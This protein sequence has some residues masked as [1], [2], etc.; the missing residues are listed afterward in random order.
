[1]TPRPLPPGPLVAF[2]GDDLTGSSAAMEVLAFAGLDTVLFLAPPTPERLAAFAGHRAVGIAGMARSQGP[3]WMDAHLP[4]VFRLLAGLGAP[5][6]HYKVC[7]T[8]DSAPHVGSIGRAAEL[9]AEVFRVGAESW[10]PMLVADPG[11]GRY[12]S[13]GHLFAMAGPDGHRLDRHP[14]MARHPVTPMDEA[15]LGRHLARQTALPVG[16]VDFVAMKRGE[17]SARLARARAAGAR[18]VSLD[19]L[20]HETL[21]EAGRLIWEEGGSPTFTVGS[22]G[23]GA[24]LVAWWREAGLLPAAPAIPVPPPVDRIAAVS[25]SVSPVTAGQ[26]A[27]AVQNGF[28]GLRIDPSLAVD[29]AAWEREVGR[30]GEAALAALGRGRDPLVYS[31]AGPDDPAV[32]ALRD[33]TRTAGLSEEVV[34]DRIGAGLGTILNRVVRQGRLTRAVI[35]GGDTSGRVAA[36]LGIDALAALAPMA[37]GAPLC[38]AYTDDGGA[39]LEIALKGGQV[40]GPDFFV[41][42]RRG[43]PTS[44]AG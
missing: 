24:A 17:G 32:A 9:G 11:M 7:S 25:G 41:A 1:M 21:V 30:A 10:I 20:D 5:V 34:N 23:V 18:I 8:F 33:A 6:A 36:R 40:G 42:V 27:H 26:I 16:L 19:V 29:P 39:G 2:Y 13:F 4:P 31:A 44:K 37:P 3:A 12:Q 14:T 15:D 28:E 22:Q 43:A 38:R 35:S